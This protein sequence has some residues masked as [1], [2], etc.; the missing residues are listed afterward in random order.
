MYVGGSVYEEV[1]DVDAVVGALVVGLSAA[2]VE[3]VA[4]G[5]AGWAG[6]KPG[7]SSLSI[8]YSNGTTRTRADVPRTQASFLERD[9]AE[10]AT[11]E[12]AVTFSDVAM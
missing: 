8:S 7:P 4:A 10:E 1:D 12:T 5:G 6:S 11:L 2:A 9:H 3:A